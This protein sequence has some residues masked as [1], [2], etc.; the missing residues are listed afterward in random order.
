MPSPGDIRFRPA[1][2]RDAVIATTV[3][4]EGFE[5]YRD[6]A[7][8]GWRPPSRLEEERDLHLRLGRGDVHSRLALGERTVAGFTSW[9]PAFTRAEPPAPIPGRAHLSALFVAPAHWGTGLAADLLAWAVTSMRDSG[10]TE[11]QL[12]TPRDH[13]RARAFYEREGWRAASDG[14]LFSP[15]LCLDLVLYLRPLD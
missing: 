6:F 14:A 9:A 2:E 15:E 7:P 13:A 11:S 1:T 5:T 4:I 10:F 8:P 3:V 12:Y